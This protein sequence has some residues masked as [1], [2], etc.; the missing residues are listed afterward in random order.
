LVE[1][2]LEKQQASKKLKRSISER[3]AVVIII[4]IIIIKIIEIN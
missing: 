2:K 4:I 3:S 1:T